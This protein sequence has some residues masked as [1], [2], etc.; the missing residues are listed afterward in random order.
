MKLRM[1]DVHLEL[2]DRFH[3]YAL[4]AQ[5][6]NFQKQFIVQKWVYYRICMSFKCAPWILIFPSSYGLCST[7]YWK[8]TVDN[9]T[10]PVYTRKLCPQ[11]Y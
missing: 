3:F 11:F 4:E 2:L 6:H 5:I 7:K 9:V 10:T 1:E 8:N